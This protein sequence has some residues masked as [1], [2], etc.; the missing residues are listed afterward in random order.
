[1]SRDFE[2]E[3]TRITPVYRPKQ[4]EKTAPCQTGCA[5]C[6][7]IRGWIGTVS[8]RA[9]TGLSREEAYTKAWQ[10][11]TEVNPFPSALGR[12]CP[13][14]CE[15][16]CNRSELDEPLAINAMERFLGD[17][18][19]EKKI[20]LSRLEAEE[21]K[22]WLGVVGA[23]PSGLSFAYQLARLGYRV[24]VYESGEKAGGMLRY[25]VPDY[26]LPQDIL[27]AEIGRI[28]DL[29]VELKLNTLVGRDITLEQ[30]RERHD[31]LYLGIGAQMGRGLGLPGEEGPSVW[32]GTE[33]LSRLNRGETIDLGARVLVIGGGNTAVDAARSARRTGAEVSILYRRTRDEMPAVDHEIEDALEE[34]VEI[35]FLVAPVRIERHA[36]GQI[37]ALE[38]CRMELGEADAS[39]RRRPLEIPGSGF[40]I[41]T[42]SL[43][44]AVSQL[45]ELKGL[46]ALNR[47]G[48]WLVSDDA[49][50]VGEGMFAGGDALGLGVAGNA[51]SQGRR[52]AEELH[53][54]FTGS[55]AQRPEDER[56]RIGPDQVRFD[57]KPEVPAAQSPKL[58]G[59]ERVRMGSAEVARTISE[60]QFL[61]ETER[62]FSC[63][64]CFGCEQCS[65]YCTTGCFTKVEEV[66]QGVYFTLAL[67]ECH[68]CGK[69]VEVCPC[70][71]LEVRSEKES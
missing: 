32:T 55:R 39:G 52:A 62:C 2:A 36:D 33:Y 58:P 68:E 15:T 45:P 34:G 31:A 54:R 60:E 19:I 64:T 17:W 6:G 24:T 22:E 35:L 10:I 56:P 69:C 7:D 38:A 61:A 48:N 59:E 12:V 29:G 43:I 1:M 18:A 30:L 71:F 47:D 46:E 42:D 21:K 51:I 40:T 26:R 27:D 23:G 63:G 67:D 70:G 50:N 53:A 9:K 25:G 14:P 5:N 28:L 41:S 66:S 57:Y 49:G 16:H 3:S 37:L 4:V 20:A 13:H 44:A 11:I 65:M 8:Q